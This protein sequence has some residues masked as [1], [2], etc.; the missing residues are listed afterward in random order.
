MRLS[1]LLPREERFFD[2]FDEAA[3]ILTR[4]SG[5]FLEMVTEYDRLTERSQELKKEEHAALIEQLH[6]MGEGHAHTGRVVDFLVHPRF[7]V[8]IRHNAKIG[9]EQLAR[10]AATKMGSASVFSFGKRGEEK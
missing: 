7:P 6:R 4:A 3:A 1:S 10:W 2:M 9:R 8:D 5:K